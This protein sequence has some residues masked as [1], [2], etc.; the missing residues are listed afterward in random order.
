MNNITQFLDKFETLSNDINKKFLKRYNKN[1]DDNK[2]DFKNTLYASILALKNKGI[3]TVSTDLDT[4]HITHVSKN[5]IIKVRNNEKSFTSIKK[6]ND[7]LVKIIYDPEN[8][9]I[10]PYNCTFSNKKN[11]YIDS[12]N[13]TDKSLFI[14]RT[15]KRFVGCDGFQLSVNKSLINNDD[16]KR[17]KS[18]E[19][20][21]ALI[22]NLFDVMNKISIN[23]GLTKSNEINFNKKKV[24]ETTGLL[25]QLY[26]L[27]SNDILILDNWYFSKE[28][29]KTLVNKNIG[30]IFRM[31]HNSKYFLDMRFETS[32]IIK[33]NEKDVQLFKY[34]IKKH[35]YY[36]LT[37]ITEKITIPEIKAL[38]WRR[39]KVE[40]DIKKFKYDILSSDIRSKKYNSF[41]VDIESIRF[42]SIIS[43]I[44]EYLGKDDLKFKKKFNTTNCIHVLYRKL[45]NLIFYS[46]DKIEIC[47]VLGIIY[48]KIISIIADRSCPRK[49]VKPSTKWNTNGNRF[50]NKKE[51]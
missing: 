10:K 33:I 43:S 25:D 44:I 46:D 37:S 41:L 22:S 45:L 30:Y 29:Q 31:K 42:M 26:L 15:L 27:N 51:S 35:E 19:Y 50:G 1:E 11:S 13:A 21:I 49:R 28:L 38:Y 8:N 36:I 9:F 47:R 48:K 7:E 3:E 20:G 23:Y 5:S 14:N 24:N 39:W 16:V 4:D 32:K 2:L 17:S 34:K 12:K 6:M 40:T 18:G